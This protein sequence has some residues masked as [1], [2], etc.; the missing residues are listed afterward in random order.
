MVAAREATS[1]FRRFWTPPRVPRH[2]PDPLS[3]LPRSLVP[4]PSLF[5]T[6]PNRTAATDELHHGHR[7]PLAP[8][9]SPRAPP[10]RLEAPP[11]R[12]HRR[13]PCRLAI[14]PSSPRTAVHRRR[15][16]PTPSVPPRARRE[17]LRDR[18]EH[19]V[20]SPLTLLP[21]W[22]PQPRSRVRPSSS[23]SP[24][25]TP[26]PTGATARRA[27]VWAL[28]RAQPR[29]ERGTTARARVPRRVWPRRRH[30]AGGFDPA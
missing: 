12:E 16:I 3:L 22:L 28:E 17:P 2:L 29:C 10:R 1:C 7:P 6:S 27:L 26:G 30:D 24:P 13:T 19:P 18:G 15:Q 8:P 20:I 23:P 9:M 4:S 11:Q 14:D 21:V 25:A 5:P